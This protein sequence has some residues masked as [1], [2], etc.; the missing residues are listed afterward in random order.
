MKT[1]NTREKILQV[2]L[3]LFSTNGF[4]ATSMFEIAENVGIKKASLY[5]HFDTK[6]D[7][8]DTLLEMITENYDQNSLFKRVNWNVFDATQFRSAD[9][10]E[11]FAISNTLRQINLLIENE[12]LIKIRRLLTIEQYRNGDMKRMQN[13]RVYDDVVNY[14]REFLTHLIGQGI[15]KSG[16]ID[17]M[18]LEYCAPVSMVLY[19]IDRNP[20][21]KDEGIELIQKHLHQFWRVY[22]KDI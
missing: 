17:A 7:I 13:K 21:F 12:D 16:D 11:E 2:S 19:N 14:H 10:A 9:E 3:D 5:N 18:T 15:L 1:S 8:V 22:R 6:Q 20:A 4:D